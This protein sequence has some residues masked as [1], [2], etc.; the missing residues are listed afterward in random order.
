MAS[1]IT[2]T[3]TV[4]LVKTI[5]KHVT[6]NCQTSFAKE[7]SI[8]HEADYCDI[9]P[10]SKFRLNPIERDEH[11]GGK[12]E[13]RISYFMILLFHLQDIFPQKYFLHLYFIH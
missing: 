5:H 2:F 1:K 9:C 12:T 10:I 7:I 11:K 8:V 3:K 6:K 13:P 4:R